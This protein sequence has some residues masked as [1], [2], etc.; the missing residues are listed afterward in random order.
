MS[1]PCTFQL[2]LAGTPQKKKP[3][4]LPTPQ[5]KNP[6][7]LPALRFEPP[8]PRFDPLATFLS[9]CSLCPKISVV[10]LVQS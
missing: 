1:R 3:M 8:A 9:V 4:D 5:K 2:A 7:D 6:M 10:D